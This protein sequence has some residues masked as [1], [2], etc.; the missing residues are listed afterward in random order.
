[1]KWYLLLK[2]GSV[3]GMGTKWVKKGYLLDLNNQWIKKCEKFK[4][5]RSE[6]IIDMFDW[7]KW[8]INSKN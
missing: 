3:L 7:F 6:Q 2:Y 4:N 1:M 5:V 8:S